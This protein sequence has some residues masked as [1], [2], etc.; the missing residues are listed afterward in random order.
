MNYY[1]K[2][3]ENIKSMF[4]IKKA[5]LLDNYDARTNDRKRSTF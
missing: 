1:Q 2:N 3:I 5:S 4:I